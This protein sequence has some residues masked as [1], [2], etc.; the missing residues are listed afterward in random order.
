MDAKVANY[1]RLYPWFSN[2]TTHF[3][4]AHERFLSIY[5]L[6]LQDWKHEEFK[7]GNKLDKIKN[8]FRIQDKE[9]NYLS[10]MECD[11]CITM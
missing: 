8:G 5:D 7:I 2:M 10:T 1:A 6:N 9:N 11:V 3:V 4:V